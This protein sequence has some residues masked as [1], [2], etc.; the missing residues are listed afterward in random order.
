MKEINYFEHMAIVTAKGELVKRVTGWN[1]L[2]A[3]QLLTGKIEKILVGSNGQYKMKVSVNDKMIGLVDF[4]N[5]SDTP[6]A[7]AV[8]KT[9]KEGRRLKVRVL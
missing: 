6:K 1:D 4:Y 8:P 2:R 9:I 5:T 7:G 3:G